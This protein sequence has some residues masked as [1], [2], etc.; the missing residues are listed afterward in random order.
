MR[1][2]DYE[3]CNGTTP[4]EKYD[5]G[6]TKIEFNRSGQYFYFIGDHGS[7]GCVSGQRLTVAVIS[8]EL[9][10]GHHTPNK[11]NHNHTAV[12]PTLSP[13]PSPN[14]IPPESGATTHGLRGGFMGIF[15]VGV[16]TLVGMA[17]FL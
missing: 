8:D 3:R 15:L 7:N 12:A 17:V 9:R 14:D 6:K 2:E 5:D 16:G 4:I 11:P 10:H 1:K 13:A